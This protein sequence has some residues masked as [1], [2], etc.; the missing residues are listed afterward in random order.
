[1]LPTEGGSVAPALSSAVMGDAVG[2]PKSI[3]IL[4]I[5]V[6]V[7]TL[8]RHTNFGTVVYAIGSKEQSARLNGARVAWT[9]VAVYAIAGLASVLAAIYYVG[10]IAL[11]AAPNAGDPYI[12][13]SI[14]A[15]AIGGTSLLGGR[16]GYIG[17]VLGC[18]SLT[19]IGS[20]VFFSGV[21]SYY[22]QALQGVLLVGAVLLYSTGQIT[23][24]RPGFRGRAK[25]NV[26]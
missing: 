25:S 26:G 9:K 18:L 5:L 17:T 24:R 4:L 8:F 3:L 22:G 1:M 11:S 13:Q 15:V 12:L 23:V 10:D 21:Q 7:F 2:I 16:G 6:L 19:M 14:A 20:I